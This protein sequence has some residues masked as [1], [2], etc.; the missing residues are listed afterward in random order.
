MMEFR[1]PCSDSAGCVAAGAGVF[2]GTAS[3]SGSCF[4]L[5][6]TLMTVST[7]A[8]V[9][10]QTLLVNNDV[11]IKHALQ[12]P[13]ALLKDCE[14]HCTRPCMYTYIL[15]QGCLVVILADLLG[16]FLR[17]LLLQGFIDDLRYGLLLLI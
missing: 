14:L 6:L 13:R 8:C 17:K 16:L 4:L 12:Q 5:P 1:D 9:P 2:S 15:L 10:S 7:V 11:L 3:G